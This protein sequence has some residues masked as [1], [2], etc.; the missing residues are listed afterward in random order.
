MSEGNTQ[1]RVLASSRLST[2][3]P[4]ATG[5]TGGGAPQ[6]SS[7]PVRSKLDCTPLQ[8]TRPPLQDRRAYRAR[9]RLGERGQ[10]PLTVEL[11][12]LAEGVAAGADV[13]LEH[14]DQKQLSEGHISPRSGT[15]NERVV[16]DGIGHYSRL[17]MHLLE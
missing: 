3:L 9:L 1:L 4:A 11:D 13:V 12:T 5:R 17:T 16:N 8:E 6:T 7:A 15:L 2:Q 14:V 10:R